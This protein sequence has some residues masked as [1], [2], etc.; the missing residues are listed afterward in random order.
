MIRCRVYF[1]AG[2]GNVTLK[3]E[4]FNQNWIS[5]PT[6]RHIIQ[7]GLNISKSSSIVG[8]SEKVRDTFSDTV[9]LDN[10]WKQDRN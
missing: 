9:S 6:Y 3:I 8:K 10:S 1:S 2:K 4:L 7:S 5:D